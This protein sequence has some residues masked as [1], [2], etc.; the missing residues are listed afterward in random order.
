MCLALRCA[1]LPLLGAY[2]TA[3]TLHLWRM[4]DPTTRHCVFFP[5]PVGFRLSA[6]TTPADSFRGQPACVLR[7]RAAAAIERFGATTHGCGRANAHAVGSCP[8]RASD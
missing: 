1:R 4:R 8:A 2:A 3:R 5:S 6:T 7:G